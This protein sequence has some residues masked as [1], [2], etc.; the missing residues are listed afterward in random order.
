[1]SHSLRRTA[2]LILHD[3][4]ESS[5][6]EYEFRWKARW[7]G[8]DRWTQPSKGKWSSRAAHS[9]REMGNGTV[10]GTWQIGMGGGMQS[11]RIGSLIPTDYARHPPP[12]LLK[13]DCGQTLL[14]KGPGALASRASATR[15][16]EEATRRGRTRISKQRAGGCVGYANR[17]PSFTSPPALP[18]P[19]MHPKLV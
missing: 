7:R 12:I 19:S 18:R 9:G 6:L 4:R 5:T 16:R 10:L 3:L 2:N 11:N 8:D 14:R 1:L 13:P 17:P 15:A